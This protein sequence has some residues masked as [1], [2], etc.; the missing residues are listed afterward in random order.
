MFNIFWLMKLP[1]DNATIQMVIMCLS[2]IKLEN[3]VIELES[4]ISLP[5]RVPQRLQGGGGRA[6][7]RD[8]D[9]RSRGLEMR[10]WGD[11]HLVAPSLFVRLPSPCASLSRH[12]E[13]KVLPQIPDSWLRQMDYPNPSATSSPR[14][15]SSVSSSAG[16]VLGNHRG[17]SRYHFS[18]NN[19]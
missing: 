14:M 3:C 7:F 13:R 17:Q 9:G 2:T 5:T 11:H 15:V 16:P 1:V 10:S 8:R 4:R 12:W 6:G 18:S 19:R